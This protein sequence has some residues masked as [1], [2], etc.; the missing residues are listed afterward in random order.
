MYIVAK[1]YFLKEPPELDKSLLIFDPTYKS[2]QF[3][4]LSSTLRG[5]YS[6]I[7]II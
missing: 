3:L 6:E 5:K 2:W 4:C 1:Q 7:I